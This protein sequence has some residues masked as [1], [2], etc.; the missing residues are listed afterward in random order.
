MNPIDFDYSKVKGSTELHNK[1]KNEFMIYASKEFSHIMIIPYDVGFFRAWSNP[2]IPV[3]CGMD[4][5]PDTIIFGLT[6]YLLFDMKT[7]KARFQ[8]NQKDF[9][10][11][12][13]VINGG[14][15]RVFKINSCLEGIKIIRQ[16]YE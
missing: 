2:D 5:V 1:F 13:R 14:K 3:R 6:W 9:Q 12:I 15:H 7:G 8:Q 11:R 10:E 16:Q 4:G